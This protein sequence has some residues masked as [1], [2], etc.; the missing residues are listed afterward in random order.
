M[1]HVYEARQH[2]TDRS[3]A[4]K[5]MRPGFQESRSRVK[6]FLHEVREASRLNHPHIVTVF[7]FGQTDAGDLFVVMELVEGEPL[8]A[9]LERERTLEPRRVALLAAQICD[10]VQYAH[11]A[12]LVHR[13]LKPDNIM[14]RYG[15]G[16]TGD[17]AT[18]L[19]FGIAKVVDD[20]RD[21]T[22]ITSTGATCG[23]PAYMSPEQAT[24]GQVDGR[25]D[26]YSLGVILYQA[27]AG[28]RPFDADSSMR[29]AMA[30][31]Y[32][33]APALPDSVPPAV[34]Q[35]VMRALSKDPDDR[36]PTP[37]ALSHE[38]LT[39]A[40]LALDGTRRL[41]PGVT[42]SQEEVTWTSTETPGASIA[43]APSSTFA[44]RR[45]GWRPALGGLA[46]G[47]ALGLGAWALSTPKL[48]PA[49][50]PAPAA[51]AE[52][53]LA[54][55]A[56][57]SEPGPALGEAPPERSATVEV[58]TRPAGASLRDHTGA[59]QGVTPA[60]LPRPEPGAPLALV[61]ELDGHAVAPIA[62]DAESEDVVVVALSPLEMPAAAPDP[63]PR[64]P[65]RRKSPSPNP[66]ERGGII[67]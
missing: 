61:A 35:C 6:R 22:S 47:L 55:P 34:R 10:A 37:T 7:D 32:D 25:A 4:V 16:T 45:T 20:A 21:V 50:S 53:S 65:A 30:H 24:G 15:V 48:Q 42:E 17:F 41:A 64:K 46:A 58:R 49:A 28:R 18:V 63:R 56:E 13:D 33:A 23:T 67:E 39:A 57:P 31:L 3:V 60:V 38:L 36:Q 29:M 27:L 26:V 66:V 43:A 19:D 5:V 40:E 14:V 1:A 8:G 44:S 2:S 11:R 9:L 12:G 62:V 52:A 54:T 59:G 51:P